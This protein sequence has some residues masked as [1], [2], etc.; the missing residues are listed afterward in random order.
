MTKKTVRVLVPLA[1]AV[2]LSAGKAGAEELPVG[3]AEMPETTTILE[4]WPSE[5]CVVDGLPGPPCTFARTFVRTESLLLQRDTGPDRIFARI[6]N[7]NNNVGTTSGIGTDNWTFDFEP[8]LRLTIGRPL[9]DTSLLEGTYFGLY[10]FDAK[11]SLSNR[12][13]TIVSGNTDGDGNDLIDTIANQATQYSSNLHSAE[14]NVRTYYN[15]YPH[16]SLLVGFRFLRMDEVFRVN[17][18]GTNGGVD[19]TSFLRQ[20]TCNSML[21][22]QIGGDLQAQVFDHLLAGIFWRT[23]FLSNINQTKN[24]IGAS[25]ATTFL[26]SQTTSEQGIDLT[27]LI[28]AGANVSI[29]L[30]EWAVL[31]GGYQLMFISGVALAP[32]QTI[33]ATGAAQFVNDDENMFLH[34]P[35]LGLEIH[36]GGRF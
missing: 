15:V 25:T 28:E 11:T 16:M 22:V 4:D 32:S 18:S 2:A 3:P 33:P 34:G 12:Q 30:C 29:D 17:E 35:H 13:V 19:A 10:D 1:L 9:G 7:T 24:E 26:A 27:G 5:G 14:L 36:W 23:G 31:H 20:E 6:L 8:G 21:G